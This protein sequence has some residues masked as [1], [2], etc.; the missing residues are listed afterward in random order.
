MA[1]VKCNI[2]RGTYNN[3]FCETSFPCNS[4]LR[5]VVLLLFCFVK[6][7]CIIS[8][9]FCLVMHESLIRTKIS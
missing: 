7:D 3:V 5:V 8:L 4:K 6:L 9:S 1:I 2:V